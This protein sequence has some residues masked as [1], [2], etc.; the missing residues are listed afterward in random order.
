MAQN[1]VKKKGRF[2]YVRKTF[3][4]FGVVLFLGLLY[5]LWV[6]YQGPLSVPFL[7]PYI[8]QAL[9]SE[10]TQYTMS[11]G[12]VNLELV[13]SIQP[14]KIIAKDVNFRKNDDT[15]AVYT[16]NLSLSFSVRALL[17]GIIAPSTVHVYHPKVSIF[18]TYGLEEGKTNELNKKKFELYVDWF[19]GFLERFNADEKIYPESY[20]NEISIEEAEVEFHEVDLARQWQFKDV[21]FN[22][23]R[24]L[25]NLE[26]Q[27]D[28]VLDLKDRLASLGVKAIYSPLNNGLTVK[29][30]FADFLPADLVTPEPD[31]TFRINVPIDGSITALMDFNQILQHRDNLTEELDTAIKKINFNIHGHAGEVVFNEEEKFNYAIDSFVLDGSIT[32][33]MNKISIQNADFETGGQKTR[34]S[35]DISGYRKFLFERALDDLKII[36]TAEI[37]QF[38]LPDLSKFWPRYLAEPAWEWCQKN[39]YAGTAT[40]GRFTFEFGFSDKTRTFG[41]QKLDGKA[42]ASDASISYLEGLPA[43]EHVYGTAL[44]DESSIDIHADKGVSDGIILTDGNVLLYDLNKTHNFIKINLQGNSTITDALRYIDNPPLNFTKEM[45]INP[46]EIK[47]DVDID[48]GLDFELSHDLKPDDVKVDVKAK[49]TDVELLKEIKGH[50]AKASDLELTV[51]NQGFF[52]KGN[53][54]LDEISFALEVDESFKP[55]DYKSKA[56][57]K[58]RLDEEVEKKLGFQSAILRA[59]YIEGYADVTADITVLDEQHTYI[60]AEAD[61]THAAIDY[62]FLGFVKP[63]EESG[64]IK[65]KIEFIDEKLSAVPM[66]ALHKNEFDLAGKLD[67]NQQGLLKSINIEKIEGPRTS[68]KAKIDLSYKENGAQSLVKI[69]VNGKSYDLTPLYE[70]L[71]KKDTLAQKTPETATDS[72]DALENMPDTDVFISVQKLWTNPKTSIRNVA[73]SANFKNGIG[74]DEMHV[75]GNFGTDK[76]IKL[77]LDYAPRP[78]NEHMLFIDSNNAGSTLRV[79]RLYD[80]MTGG[81]LKIEAKRD[82]NKNFIGHARIRDFSIHN[83]PLLAKVLTVASFSGIVDLLTGEGLS[84]SHF[85]A[86]FEYKNSILFLKNANMFGNVLGINANGTVNKTTQDVKLKG[87]VSP[88]YS[89]NQFLGRIPLVGTALAGKDGT[90]FAV[91]YA[92]EGKLDNPKIEINPLSVLS[93]NSIKDLFSEPSGGYDEP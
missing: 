35:L 47:G 79:L 66:F 11:I 54:S 17:N 71:E 21:A 65:A 89:I 57:V 72:A 13:R 90:I 30:S 41:L 76:S 46:N 36:F 51:D 93:P 9:N 83:T 14:V 78:N 53:A 64:Q 31:S 67:I 25:L 82:Q 91:N 18:T 81:I 92:V 77:K 61:L 33:D 26:L 39:L 44:F 38:S 88:A 20:I 7:K 29:T 75:F 86:P 4:Y 59:P 28:G 87:I 2:Y 3:D 60:D 45:G 24:N 49:L 52:V 42:Y 16:P 70:N 43:V 63:L 74:L 48:L 55:R 19:E 73:A 56:Q 10:D 84:F 34:L 32:G 58:F 80:N 5:C 1:K 62:A 69:D 8:M 40:D 15:F 12:D 27:A 6:L 22:F 68:A 37:D 23:K 85:D 50:H